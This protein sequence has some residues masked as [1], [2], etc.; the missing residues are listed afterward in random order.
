MICFPK[1]KYILAVCLVITKLSMPSFALLEIKTVQGQQKFYQLV[2]DE[3][4]LFDAFWQEIEREG[5]LAG[6]LRRILAIMNQVAQLKQ[7]L[8]KTV[9]RELQGR[10]KSDHVKEYEVKTSNLRVYLFHKEGTGK[11]VVCAGKKN[12]QY[13]DIKWF[14]SLKKQ[15]FEVK[16]Y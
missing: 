15:Y 11:I 16:P 9:F 5:N 3:E 8:P 12:T 7:R 2:V 6:E 13:A 1:P 10:K 4:R 14:R